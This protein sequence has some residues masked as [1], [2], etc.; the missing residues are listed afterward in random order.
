MGASIS[1]VDVQRHKSMQFTQNL[2]PMYTE[3]PTNV[4]NNPSLGIIPDILSPPPS[5]ILSLQFP[6]PHDSLLL[7]LI[8]SVTRFRVP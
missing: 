3:S 5:W 6:N 7:P 4:P 8:A 1:H 2:Q